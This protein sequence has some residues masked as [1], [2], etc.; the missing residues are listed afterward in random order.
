MVVKLDMTKVYDIVS[1]IFLTKVMRKF[2]FS[3]IIIDMVWR[4][5]LN[6]WYSICVN[7]QAYGLF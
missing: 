4:L 2:D 5:L 7:G 3:E 6:N 1:R